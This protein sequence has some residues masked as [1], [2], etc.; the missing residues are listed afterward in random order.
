MT[1]AGIDL[2]LRHRDSAERA[3]EHGRWHVR[4]VPNPAA[5]LVR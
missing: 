3:D 1:V 4:R 5:R 2:Q